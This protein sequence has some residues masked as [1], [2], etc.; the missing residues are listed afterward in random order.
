MMKRRSNPA[1]PVWY[2]PSPFPS[3]TSI[4]DEMT[5]QV[6]SGFSLSARNQRAHMN[7]N[8]NTNTNMNTNMN[9]NTHTNT[10]TNTNTH[11]SR[12][13]TQ[14]AARSTRTSSTRAPR[15]HSKESKGS[16]RS[17]EVKRRPRILAEGLDRTARHSTSASHPS[18]S[19]V[20]A[21]THSTPPSS[22]EP[23]PVR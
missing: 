7:M 21:S 3:S 10:N 9:T 12:R 19:A 23:H 5:R 20:I 16:K 1:R 13:V 15:T 22:N 4:S 18:I 6:F 11:T 17:K 14:R 2:I 8:T